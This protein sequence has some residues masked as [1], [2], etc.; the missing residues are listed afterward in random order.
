MIAGEG[1]PISAGRGSRRPGCIQVNFKPIY[2]F[3]V[4][5]TD[6]VSFANHPLPASVFRDV[7]VELPFILMHPKPVE[8]PMSRPQ[9]G[10]LTRSPEFPRKPRCDMLMYV[11]VCVCVAAL[12][13]MDPPIDTNLIEFD[14]K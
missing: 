8:L 14:T 4:Q 3:G 2:V 9:S 1:A 7:S 6:G 10:D 12:P 11:F 13:E 5:K